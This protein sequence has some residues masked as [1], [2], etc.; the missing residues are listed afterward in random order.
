MDLQ[1]P[2]GVGGGQSDVLVLP[3]AEAVR[4]LELRLPLHFLGQRPMEI[5]Q[6]VGVQL[7][8]LLTVGPEAGLKPGRRQVRNLPEVGRLTQVRLRRD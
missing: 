7:L 1:S 5:V 8:V 6:K 3:G 4:E 2:V